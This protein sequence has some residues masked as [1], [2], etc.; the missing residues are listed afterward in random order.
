MFII[1]ICIQLSTYLI[2]SLD[3]KKIRKIKS[4]FGFQLNVT[5]TKLPSFEHRLGLPVSSKF[6]RHDYQKPFN[7]NAEK[8][9]FIKQIIAVY[10]QLTEH[11]VTM[12]M[13]HN[14]PDIFPPGPKHQKHLTLAT[15]CQ[16]SVNRVEEMCTK[17]K[18]VNLPCEG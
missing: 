1:I 3:K 11:L 12:G 8:S 6:L 16:T 14:L 7:L 10:E 2:I 15:V 4:F 5:M 13:Q 17:E 9:K 18:N